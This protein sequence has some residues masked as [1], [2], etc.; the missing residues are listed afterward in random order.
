MKFQYMYS[1]GIIKRFI[2]RKIYQKKKQK[3]QKNKKTRSK[4]EEEE[5]VTECVSN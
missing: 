2:N 3:K 5:E 4:E 1:Q